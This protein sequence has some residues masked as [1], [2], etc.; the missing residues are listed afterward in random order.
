MYMSLGIGMTLDSCVW[1]NAYPWPQDPWSIEEVDPWSTEEVRVK[2]KLGGNSDIM[3]CSPGEETRFV[4]KIKIVTPKKGYIWLR[5]YGSDVNEENLTLIN[6]FDLS[7]FSLVL[8]T[9]RNEIWISVSV[10]TENK[11]LLFSA[12]S[13][14]PLYRIIQT[15]YCNVNRKS[16]YIGSIIEYIGIILSI[17]GG[18]KLEIQCLH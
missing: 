17:N 13:K 10:G 9:E 7:G 15:I 12:I 14:P 2:V 18:L 16:K 8:L 3:W 6:G 1:F 11:A 5:F 4:D